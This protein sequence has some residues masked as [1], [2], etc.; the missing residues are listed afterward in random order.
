MIGTRQRIAIS[1]ARRIFLIVSGHQEPAL[2]V[3]SLATTTTSLPSTLPTT[4]TTPAAGA[5]PIS[6]CCLL[7][8]V[9][10]PDI[11]HKQPATQFPGNSCSYQAAARYVP[12]QSV[13]L[14]CA[15]SQFCLVRHP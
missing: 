6:S 10:C 3:A 1:C 12:A 2:T 13:C 4:V 11:D 9:C 7:F 8:A 14:A 15:A 5:A